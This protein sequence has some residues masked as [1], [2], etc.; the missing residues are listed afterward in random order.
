MTLTT[1]RQFLGGAVAFA[2][3]GLRAGVAGSAVDAELRAQVA[4]GLIAGG[5]CGRVGGSL[6]VA[7]LQVWTPRPVPMAAD[8]IFDLAS[9]G[10]TFTSYLCAKLYAEGKLDPD[11]PFTRYLPQHVLARESCAITVR[12]L[13]MHTGGFDNAKP[14]ITRDPAAY[15]RALFAKRPVRPRSVKF[16]YACSNYVYLGRI[17][18]NLT[19]LDL[20]TAARRFIWDPLGMKDTCWHNIP[21]HPRAVQNA[22]NGAP[23]IGVKGDEAARVYPRAEGNGAAFS[24]AADMLRFADDLLHRRL[25]PKAAYDLLFTCGFEKDGARRSFGWDMC[26]RRTPPRWSAATISHGGFTGNTL[27]IDPG[28]G[29]AAVVLTNRRGDWEAGYAG[30][31]RLLT[32]LADEARA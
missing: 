24:T 6:H 11:A 16:E 9:V 2:C 26:A 7:G 12:D 27:A 8:S 32:L 3:G 15:D 30:R 13:A 17:V 20:E 18:Q 19:G 25:L 1:R 31:G 4:G 22:L 29:V 10:K 14:Y 28:R 5:V 21:G 23:P